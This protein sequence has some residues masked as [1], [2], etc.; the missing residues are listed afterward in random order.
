MN[1][2]VKVYASQQWVEEKLNSIP[3]P[4]IATPI[5][6]HNSSTEAHPDIRSDISSSITAL[7][8]ELLN[9][10]GEAYDTLKELGDLIDENHNAIEALETVAT[11]KADKVHSHD[12]LY[13]TE[14]EVD[15]MFD[16]VETTVSQIASGTIVVEK[17][18]KDAT[19]NI[20][21]STYETKSDATTKFN[22][23]KTYAE[24]Q[25]AQVKTDLI[26]GADEE[27]DTLKK[28]G[29]L[30]EENSSEIDQLT[31]NKQNKLNGTVGQV[32]G[33]DADGNAIA[34]DNPQSD[35]N[36]NDE[37]APDYVKNKPIV[38]IGIPGTLTWDGNINDKCV[39][40]GSYFKISNITPSIADVK[41]GYYNLITA[42]GES[43]VYEFTT[44]LIQQITDFSFFIVNDL[45]GPSIIFISENDVGIDLGDNT[46]ATESGTYFLYIEESGAHISSLTIQDYTG[47]ATNKIDPS[48]LYQS[49]WCQNDKNSPDYVKNRTHY[50]VPLINIEWNG[51]I[52]GL[53]TYNIGG[54][55]LYKVADVTGI[56]F[57]GNNYLSGTIATTYDGMIT[58]GESFIYTFEGNESGMYPINPGDILPGVIIS[59]ET[60]VEATGFPSA[61]LY[62]WKYEYSSSIG[63]CVSSV[64]I[65]NIKKIDE[66]YVPF[67]LNNIV[68]GSGEY[69]IEI[70]D[71]E[72]TTLGNHSAA[73]GYGTFVYG[74]YSHAEGFSSIG[75]GSVTLS[76]DAN[77]TTYSLNSANS[78]IEVGKILRYNNNY[79]KI[80]AYS[81]DN[82]TITLDKTLSS[83]ALLNQ[84]VTRIE[85]ETVVSGKYSHAEGRGT[86]VFSDAQHVQGQYNISDSDNTYAHIVG[87][88]TSSSRRSNAHTLDWDGNAWFQGD[89]YIG[90][91]SGTDKDEGSVKLQKEI[92]VTASDN[93]KFLRVVNGAW[94]AATVP[95]AEEVA[96]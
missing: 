33:F 69:S 44:D 9:G 92:P 5:N 7:K 83:E 85:N 93:G 47:F 30:I 23:A 19:G 11:S 50:T 72:T 96:F 13:Y 68:D 87:N 89:V 12:D 90:S 52:T 2:N 42:Q 84:S 76:G 59:N 91:T 29:T 14:L 86:L 80:I 36:Q 74:D 28:L 27:H 37:T 43:V 94:A 20:I 63:V 46:I 45:G 6:E 16:A 61:G 71:Q 64:T 66:K 82:L 17:A 95:N 21:N 60:A 26:D 38:T 53:D 22:N 79:A 78:A 32:V 88:G 31:D 75:W 56:D 67:K 62:L 77:A 41:N 57:S 18:N 73:M 48:Y 40:S 81:P 15:N 10:A 49:D 24:Q 58:G 4:D 1:N 35:W 51:D 55:Q 70:A 65:E 25:A 3:A 8:D 39:F 34:Q 54:Y